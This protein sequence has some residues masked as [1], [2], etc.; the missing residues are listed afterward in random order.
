M[1]LRVGVKLPG[2]HLKQAVVPT[3][4]RAAAGAWLSLQE[5][6]DKDSWGV[7]QDSA[8]AGEGNALYVLRELY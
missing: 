1:E 6:A 8:A 4:V 2:E 5:F 3:R 7:Q